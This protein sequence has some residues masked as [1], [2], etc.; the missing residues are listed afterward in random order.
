MS[1]LKKPEHKINSAKLSGIV[2]KAKKGD[3]KAAEVLVNETAD[4]IYYYCLSLLRD[5]DKA[6]DAVQDIYVILFGKLKTLKDNKSF[7][8]WLKV[9]TANYCKDKINRSREE[10]NLDDYEYYLEDEDIQ[11]SPEKNIENDEL[12]SSVILAIRSLPDTQRECILMRYYQDMSVKQISEI[13]GVKEGT[14]KSRLYN[15]RNAI[16]AELEKLGIDGSSVGGFIAYSLIR[17]SEQ[18]PNPAVSV[19]KIITSNSASAVGTEALSS[20][21][22]GFSAGTAA[23]VLPV[24][25]AAIVLGSTLAVGG[26][27][28]YYFTHQTPGTTDI[29]TA[30]AATEAI[31]EPNSTEPDMSAYLKNLSYTEEDMRKEL[32]FDETE[33]NLNSLNNK[34]YI[35]DRMNNSIDYFDTMFGSGEIDFMTKRWYV[36]FYIDKPNRQYKEL[37]YDMTDIVPILGYDE[38]QYIYPYSYYVRT[39]ENLEVEWQFNETE[40]E[41]MKLQFNPPFTDESSSPTLKIEEY[42]K[43]NLAKRLKENDKSRAVNT[44]DYTDKIDHLKYIDSRKRFTNGDNDGS[45]RADYIHLPTSHLIYFPYSIILNYELDNFDNWNIIQNHIYQ[46][47]VTLHYQTED[48]DFEI[49]VNKNTGIIESCDNTPDFCVTNF[50]YEIDQ[51]IDQSV[52]DNLSEL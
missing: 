15:A 30:V 44:A 35:F 40:R 5:E 42:C 38:P 25:I 9:I 1:K 26:V 13:L 6:L 27:G 34:E 45:I 16:K 29:T 41:E 7:L 33:E 3:K 43:S 36:V 20:A 28:A 50:E 47:T 51:P 46:D 8:G 11:I 12:C 19:D 18:T 22:K 48:K 23:A 17:D 21:A 49:I 39:S 10:E 37:V 52:F 24:K 31:T 2:A 14:V 32:T 4:Y